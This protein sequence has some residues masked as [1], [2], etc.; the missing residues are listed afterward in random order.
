[1]PSIQ[2]KI[3][4]FKLEFFV[5]ENV[6]NKNSEIVSEAATW[7][8]MSHDSKNRCRQ[9]VNECTQYLHLFLVNFCRAVLSPQV[10]TS[11]QHP[12]KSIGS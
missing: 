7:H 11:G 5:I 9:Q 6:P 3:G 10:A 2:T 12:D 1:M 4:L 8:Q